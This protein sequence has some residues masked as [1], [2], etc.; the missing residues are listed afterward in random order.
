VPIGLIVDRANR[1][2]LIAAG[3][4]V[5]TLATIAS[6]FVHS[7][8]ALFAARVF[9][10]L[11]EAVVVPGGMSLIASY[12]R[13]QELGRATGIFLMGAEA[14]KVIAYLGGGALLSALMLQGATE[15][16]LAHFSPW[17][18]LFLFAGLPGIPLVLLMLSL[19]EP[20]RTPSQ[21]RPGLGEAWRYVIAGRKA[22]GTHCAYSACLMSCAVIIVAWSPSFFVREFEI[23]ISL[24]STIVALGALGGGMVGTWAGGWFL[25]WLQRQEVRGAPAVLVIASLAITIPASIA[26][27][28]SHDLLIAACGYVATQLALLGGG[29]AIYSGVQMLTPER[30]RGVIAAVLFA[31]GTLVAMGVAMTAVGGLNDH[32]FA[33][34][35]LGTSILITIAIFATAGIVIA[36]RARTP[37][38]QLFETLKLRERA[39]S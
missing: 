28:Q 7:F 19:K 36:V 39:A 3:V 24:A 14:G 37:F 12:A 13:P 27:T 4:F 31:I 10:G 1:C 11:G 29:P 25:D 9:V 8:E 22:F 5:W 38:Q 30:S 6:A 2:R 23:D 15:G 32:L 33:E 35:E 34:A 17:Q 16:I 26:Y 18:V 20:V 21:T